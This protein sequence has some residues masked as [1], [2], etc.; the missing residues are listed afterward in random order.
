MIGTCE[1]KNMIYLTLNFNIV[2]YRED[3]QMVTL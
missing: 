2:Y 3:I 1:K